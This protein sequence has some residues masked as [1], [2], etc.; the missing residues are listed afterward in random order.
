MGILV[1]LPQVV[2]PAVQGEESFPCCSVGR[3]LPTGDI[4]P[5]ISSMSFLRATVLHQLLQYESVFLRCSPSGPHVLPAN[6]LQRGFLSSW[7]CRSLPGACSTTGFSLVHSLLSSIH[8]LWHGILHRLL[9]DLWLCCGT[10]W[11][12]GT[13]LP[14]H[15]LQGNLCSGASLVPKYSHR[16][17]KNT[18]S[19]LLFISI[20]RI[21]VLLRRF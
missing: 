17:P 5:Q 10:P 1:S 7:I 9:V 21:A 20:F 8:L 19:Y 11:A 16:N 6:L 14:H 2:S 13:E 15:G 4:S 3:T 12:A 18:A